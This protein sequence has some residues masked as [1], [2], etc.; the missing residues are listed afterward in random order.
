MI[1]SSARTMNRGYVMRTVLNACRDI[2]RSSWYKKVIP[3]TGGI[4]AARR[5]TDAPRGPLMESIGRLEPRLREALLVRHY[6][7]FNTRETASMLGVS[8][9]IVRERLRRAKG[10]LPAIMKESGYYDEF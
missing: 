10:Q 6:L 3:S 1:N 2:R 9:G 5:S 4:D 7:G 8:E